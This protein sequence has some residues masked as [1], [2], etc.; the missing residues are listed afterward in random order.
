MS[1]K[2]RAEE[3]ARIGNHS[4]LGGLKEGLV[5]GEVGEGVRDLSAHIRLR[6][7]D[8]VCLWGNEDLLRDFKHGCG[9]LR[10]AFYRDHSDYGRVDAG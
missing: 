7:T 10:F 6:S 5:G 8:F 1:K 9:M 2:A 4:Y 3:I